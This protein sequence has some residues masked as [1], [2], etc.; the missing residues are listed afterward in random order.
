MSLLPID[1]SENLMIWWYCYYY[2]NRFTALLNLFRD[3]FGTWPPYL[4]LPYLR[5]GRHHQAPSSAQTIRWVHCASPW[6]Q[7]L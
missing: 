5:G 2:Y 4:T 3:K 6:S 7:R 1:D